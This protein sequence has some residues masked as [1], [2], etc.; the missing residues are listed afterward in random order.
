MSFI[1]INEG[2]MCNDGTV[3]IFMLQSHASGLE[4]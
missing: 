1:G 4:M 3:V 2:A